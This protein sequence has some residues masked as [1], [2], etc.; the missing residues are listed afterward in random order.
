VQPGNGLRPQGDGR[1]NAPHMLDH[2]QT[3]SIDQVTMGP[4]CKRPRGRG[5]E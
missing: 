3:V 1:C 4:L 5:C 2:R